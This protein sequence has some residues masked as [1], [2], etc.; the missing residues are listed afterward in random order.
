MLI[1]LRP[2]QALTLLKEI[3]I[4]EVRDDA[5][6][7]T[8]RQLAVILTVY[9]EPPPHTIRGMAAKLRR[10]KAGDYPRP[11]HN[12]RIWSGGSSP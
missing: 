4:S 3:A 12:G 2:M 11:R 7:L 6:D 10:D 5:H 8:M 1:E 9:L